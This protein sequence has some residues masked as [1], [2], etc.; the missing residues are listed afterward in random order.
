[1]VKTVLVF[2]TTEEPLLIR[3]LSNSLFIT[4]FPF[5]TIWPVQ[6]KI[7]KYGS[8]FFLQLLVYYKNNML[9]IVHCPKY[10]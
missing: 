6:L 4:I 9:G 7:D 10:I 5:E 1:M 8:K 3:I 2:G